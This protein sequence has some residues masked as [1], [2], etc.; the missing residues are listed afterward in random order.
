MTENNKKPIIFC[1]GVHKW[2]GDFHALRGID[3]V[4]QPQEV[5]VILAPP[6]LVNPPLSAH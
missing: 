3:M 4:V 6:D 5:I 1:Q 2:F